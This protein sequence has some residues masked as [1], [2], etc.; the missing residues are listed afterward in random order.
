MS[1]FDYL[2]GNFQTQEEAQA[3]LD[4]QVAIL[5]ARDAAGN[6][7]DKT[8]AFDQMFIGNDAQ[9]ESVKDAYKSGFGEGLQTGADNIASTVWGGL[10]AVPWQVWAVGAGVAFLWLGGGTMLL[11]KSKGILAK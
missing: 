4:R 1:L 7:S 5:Q 9:A 3:N 2:S 8:A 11:K 10:K 6:V